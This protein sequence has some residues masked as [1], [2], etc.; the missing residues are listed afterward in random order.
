MSE[1][2][3]REDAKNTLKVIRDDLRKM[4][5]A[6]DD[7]WGCIAAEQIVDLHPQ[8]IETAKAVHEIVWHRQQEVAHNESH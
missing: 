3:G 8:T 1:V 4:Y 5:D 7:L 6:I 2:T